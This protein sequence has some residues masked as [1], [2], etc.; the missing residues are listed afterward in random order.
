MKMTIEIMKMTIKSAVLAVTGTASLVTCGAEI[1]ARYR[2]QWNDE[3]NAGIDERIE[4]YRKA[5]WSGGG[6]PAGAEVKVEQVSHAFLFGSH[7]FNFDQLG[8]DDWNDV[9]KATFTNLWNAATVGFYW[10]AYEPE[11]G[12]TRFANGPRDGAAFWNTQAAKSPEEK[13]K[14]FVEWR[15]PA[16]DPILDFCDA[17]GISV[18]GHTMIYGGFGPEWVKSIADE[19]LLAQVYEERIRT[20]GRHYGARIPQ[21]D[22]VNESV[23]R[24]STFDAPDD[25]RSWWDPKVPL[26][27]DYTFRSFGWAAKYFPASVRLAINDAGVVVNPYVP[28]IRRLLDRGA[29]IDVVGMQMHIFKQ[30]DVRKIAAGEQ[31]VTNQQSWDPVDQIAAF[32][33]LDRLGKPIH[34]SEITIP[35]PDDSDEGQEVQARLFRDNYRLWFSWPSIYRITDWNLVDYTYYKEKLPS[36]LYTYDMRKKKAYHAL[37]RLINHEWKTRLELKADDAGRVAFRGFKGRY[38]LSWKTADGALAERF[39]EVR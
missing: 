29:K 34:L 32:Q 30:Q 3:I 2:E 18:H 16:P 20:L 37:D 11:R 39:E 19:T 5:D 28:F 10:N 8:R 17:H 4:R 35:A 33:K 31:C 9:Y 21:W 24:Q 12:S 26:P 7:I 22:V 15:R 27:H 23:N 38:R 25:V 13:G 36:G 14:A 6:F 1:P